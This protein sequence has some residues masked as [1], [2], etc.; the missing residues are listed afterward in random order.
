MIGAGRRGGSRAFLSAGLFAALALTLLVP[1][2]VGFLWSLVDPRSGWFAPALLPGGLA[3]VHWERALASPRLVGGVLT[4]LF[5]STVVTALSAAIALPT[6][7]ALA[8]LP[9][10]FKRAVEMFVLAPLIVPGLVVGIGVGI[11]FF[12]LGLAHSV[13]GV[14]LVQTVGTLPLMIRIVAAA[15]EAIPDDLIHAA[16]T[17]GAGPVRVGL[18]VVAPLAWPGYV[19]GGLLSFVTS[20]EEFEKT[21]IVGSPVVQTLTILLWQ[22]LG[23][24]AIVF[25][26]AAVV[27]FILL[28]PV[29][30][31]FALG[32]WLLRGEGALAAGM[33]KL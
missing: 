19:A 7:Y 31:I 13:P 22:N 20:F 24:Q 10:R 29:L 17:L 12:R 28:T 21:F 11:L 1:L 4:S 16:R 18:L 32:S 5:I 25:P 23:G 14:I 27:T 6:A 8:K 9:F 15:I 26:N 2:A 33:G 3:T 30:L